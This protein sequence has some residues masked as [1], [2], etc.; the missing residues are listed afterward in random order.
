M[1]QLK[2]HQGVRNEEFLLRDQQGELRTALAA[3]ELIKL[4]G[5]ASILSMLLD[6]TERKRTE[7][8]LA[9]AIQA[10]ME[11]ASWFSQALLERLAQIRS[12]KPVQGEVTELTRRERQVLEQVARGATN[13]DIAQE[14]GISHQT[15]QNILVTYS[16][17]KAYRAA[18][19]HRPQR[20]SSR[21][22]TIQN[23]H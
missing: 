19:D 5:E 13:E 15:V 11:D 14:L 7:E 21:S 23:K 2:R 22:S 12:T 10:L 8:E 16:E 17:G 6:I 3:F 9:Q 18:K 1:E 4:D 20:K